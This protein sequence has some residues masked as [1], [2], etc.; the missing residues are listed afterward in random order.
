MGYGIYFN[1]KHR[2]LIR[3]V[4]SYEE[5]TLTSKEM[6]LLY[7]PSRLQTWSVRRVEFDLAIRDFIR[8]CDIVQNYLGAP[9]FGETW[10]NL[11][12]SKYPGNFFV[13]KL[14]LIFRAWYM[15]SVED[16]LE[17]VSCAR[18]EYFLIREIS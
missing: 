7:F 14:D 6:N 16:Q 18:D 3:E 8:F 4:S 13:L 1:E 12:K 17:V 9:E 15:M 11:H 2:L 10:L 5:A